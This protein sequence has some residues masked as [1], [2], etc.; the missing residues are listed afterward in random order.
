MRDAATGGLLVKIKGYAEFQKNAPKLSPKM[1][2]KGRA[3]SDAERAK[4][5]EDLR[6]RMG[7]K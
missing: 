3:L 6:K 2:R 4:A 1:K 7:R 5:L